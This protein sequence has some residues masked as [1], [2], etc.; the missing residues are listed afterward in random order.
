MCACG[1]TCWETA[2]MLLRFLRFLAGKCS[3]IDHWSKSP[4]KNHKCKRAR[5]TPK[6]YKAIK[7]LICLCFNHIRKC[8][9]AMTQFVLWYPPV[10]AETI[11]A[12]F[13][14][15]P[16]SQKT[17]AFSRHTEMFW[18]GKCGRKMRLPCLAG[19]I[20]LATPRSCMFQVWLNV[21]G[22]KCISALSHYE[23]LGQVQYEVIAHLRPER[24]RC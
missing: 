21:H 11:V 22:R 15:V 13:V 14:Y 23:S 9:M 12:L 7:N 1:R 4:S 19:V 3:L 16:T 17:P 20:G 2:P 24:C 18:L 10:S 8:N 6:R 5:M